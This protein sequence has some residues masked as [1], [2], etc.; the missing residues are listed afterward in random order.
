MIRIVLMVLHII[1]SLLLIG[2]ILL[3]VQGSGLS[4]AFGGGLTFYRSRRSVERILIAI[5]IASAI[6]FAILSIVLLLPF[7][8]FV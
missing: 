8:Q 5:T 2:T 3:Q 1:V 6:L 7:S 4:S